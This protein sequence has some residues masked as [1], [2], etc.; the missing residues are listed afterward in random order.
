[1]LAAILN[2][3]AARFAQDGAAETNAAG[4]CGT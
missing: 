2:A 3:Y 1:M 4:T